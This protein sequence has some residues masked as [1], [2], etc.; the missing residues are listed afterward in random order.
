MSHR[1]PNANRG[2]YNS[3]IK[4][5]VSFSFM[6]EGKMQLVAK[7]QATIAVTATF[8]I[9]QV[10]IEEH[11]IFALERTLENNYPTVSFIFEEMEQMRI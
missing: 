5:G 7:D 8:E 1:Y 11:G 9:T 3:G 2:K 10:K 6:V 4:F